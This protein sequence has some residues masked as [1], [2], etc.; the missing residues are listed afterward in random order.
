MLLR[1]HGERGVLH[2]NIEMLQHTRCIYNDYAQTRIDCLRKEQ[3]QALFGDMVAKYRPAHSHIVQARS[4]YFDYSKRSCT[5]QTH[6]HIPKCA[7]NAVLFK[8]FCF[9]FFLFF[10]LFLC[11]TKRA[12]TSQNGPIHSSRKYITT[13]LSTVDMYQQHMF[14]YLVFL[15][16]FLFFFK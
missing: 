8:L 3:I 10:S 6:T 13:T 7:I 9:I 1:M 16:F 15:S 12:T 2:I 4:F 11:S 5:V 14:L